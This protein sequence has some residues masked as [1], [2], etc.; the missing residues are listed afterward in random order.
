MPVARLCKIIHRLKINDFQTF[1]PQVKMIMILNGMFYSAV[2]GTE[3]L[4]NIE[5]RCFKNIAHG[6]HPKLRNSSVLWNNET[7]MS[8]RTR[9]IRN[10]WVIKRCG[11]TYIT[12]EHRRWPGK[13][14]QNLV[15]GIY[16]NSGHIVQFVCITLKVSWINYVS[17]VSQ[18]ICF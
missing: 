1:F 11:S 4:D 17:F 3:Y 16:W 2:K 8:V 15:S 6:A 18:E 12:C 7:T 13:F 14:V 5:I 10:R 9:Y